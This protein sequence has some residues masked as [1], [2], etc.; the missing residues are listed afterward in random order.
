MISSEI[1]KIKSLVEEVLVKYPRTRNSDKLLRTTIKEWYGIEA[2][3][4][5]VSRLR[6]WFQQHGQYEATITVRERRKQE[7][8]NVREVLK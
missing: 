3:P 6:R 4:E 7:S 5:S 1:P 8:E 2:N